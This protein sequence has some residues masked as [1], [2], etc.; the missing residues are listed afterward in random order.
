MKKKSLA[1]IRIEVLDT[2]IKRNQKNEDLI[3]QLRN[4][5]VPDE[6]TI[7][8]TDLLSEYTSNVDLIEPTDLELSQYS[9]WFYLKDKK[10]FGA[11]KK[12]SGFLNPII[13]KGSIDE[14]KNI[15]LEKSMNIDFNNEFIKE[16][17][18]VAKTPKYTAEADSDEDYL[19]QIIDDFEQDK[20]IVKQVNPNEIITIEESLKLYNE[21]ISEDEIKAWVY[22]KRLY[23]NPMRGYEKYYLKTQGD[24]QNVVVS[25]ESFSIKNQQFQ[26]V[27]TIPPN[28][29]LGIKTKFKNE[30]DNET[31]IVVRNEFNE[32]FYVPLSKIEEKN[33]GNKVDETELENLVRKKALCYNDGEYQPIPIF[34][35]GNLYDLRD[36]LIGKFDK[37]LSKYTGG[38]IDKIEDK[39]GKDVAQWHKEVLENCIKEKGELLFNNPDKSRRPFLSRDNELSESFKIKELNEFSGVNFEKIYQEKRD[40]L[41]RN[42]R[43]YKEKYRDYNYNFETEY[44]LFEAFEFWFNSTINDTMLENTTKLN[45]QRL[46]INELNYVKQSGEEDLSTEEINAKKLSAKIEGEKL[47]NEFI[48]TCLIDSD[49][50]LLNTLFNRQFNNVAK[51]DVS[52]IPVAFEANK[53]VFSDPEF[54]LKLVQRNGLAFMSATNGGCY[55]YGVG[56]GK[57][58]CAIHT[59]AS[60]LKEGKVKRPLIV[61]P[62]PVYKNWI[63]E[64]FG[65]YSNGVDTS[66]DDFE[67]AKFISGALTGLNYKFN[68]WTNLTSYDIQNKEVEPYTIT[69]VTYQGA[70]KIGYSPSL[71]EAFA[72]ELADILKGQSVGDTD[73][74]D[75]KTERKKEILNQSIYSKLG[76]AESETKIDIDICGFDYL[77]VDEAHNFKN[78]FGTASLDDDKKDSWKLA[79]KNSTKRAIK[80]FLN[81]LY[82][83]RKYNGNVVLLTATPF[84]N[85]PLE[86]YSMMSLVGYSYLKKYNIQNMQSFLSLFIETISEYTVDHT[87]KIKVGTV[88]KSFQNKNILR[89]VLY[90]HFD[91]QDNPELAGVSRPCKINF[92]N[93]KVNTYLSMSDTQ[94]Q[95]REIIMEEVASYDPRTNRGAMGRALNWSK[96]NSLCPFL[97]PNVPDF[98]SIEEFVNESPKI[99]YTID[100]INSV[101]KYADERG[102]LVS[103]QVIYSNR[104][105]S[106]FPVIKQALNEICDFKKKV[107]FGNEIVDEV[108][109][110][111]S[112]NSLAD[113][114]R[115]EI[116]KD[117]FN[118]GY[119]KVIIGTATIKEGVNLQENGSV[120][121]NLDLDWNPTDFIQ[122]EGRI[123][124]QGNKFKYVRIVV[125]LVQNTLDSFINQKL[126]EKSKRIATIWDKTSITATEN[127][128]EEN[129]MVDPMEIKFA[130]IDDKD[131]LSKMK[132]DEAAKKLSKKLSI[133]E[134]RYKSIFKI[135]QSKNDYLYHKEELKGSF[136][137]TL[138][139][140]QKLDSYLF[141]F[142][143]EK[144]DWTTK[145]Q[146]SIDKAIKNLK[147]LLLLLKEYD[148]SG[149]V[150]S[151]N[152][153]NRQMN[154]RTFEFRYDERRYDY[155]ELSRIY[156]GTSEWGGI[157]KLYSR[158]L[159][160]MIA[161]YGDCK[162][163]ERAVLQSYGMTLADDLSVVKNKFLDELNAVKE[164]IEFMSTEDYKNSVYRE[165]EE[166]LSKRARNRGGIEER[167][168]EFETSNNLLTYPFDKK[169]ANNCEYPINDSPY[170]DFNKVGVSFKLKEFDDT[171]SVIR[172]SKSIKTKKDSEI[173]FLTAD[174]KKFVPDFQ[175]KIIYKNP[176]FEDA[177]VRVNEQVANCPKT[178][179]TE[180]IDT[181]EKIAQLHYFRGES[182]WYII[183][184]DSEDRQL[185][186]FGYVILNGDEQ[187]AEFGYINIEEVKKYAELDL[188]WTPVKM[189]TLLS[190]GDIETKLEDA[191]KETEV[192]SLVVNEAIDLLSNLL[193]V[194]DKKMVKNAKEA[195]EL[196]KNLL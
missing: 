156:G 116:I 128:I 20:S 64:L 168:A 93:S 35:F 32:L 21:S 14:F 114:E 38:Y 104:G 165:I 29:Q 12:G 88:I 133:A 17:I 106:I 147:E 69:L 162:K 188:Y 145:D 192:T 50:F 107:K 15:K 125:P 120:L 138:S 90:R 190:D 112:A 92:P 113:I 68:D 77:V 81:S 24:S 22:Y 61:V 46:Y 96:S 170:S 110:V 26:D 2:L 181:E 134:D 9:N 182:D 18:I 132:I 127:K 71:R 178:Y 103:G 131:E 161:N 115:K 44:T 122:L 121:Y 36:S 79:R 135:E 52:K 153:A 70:E 98:E 159:Q 187:N 95:A 27:K 172:K 87:N 173:T 13:T 11:E 185:Q 55:A 58:L 56:F 94:V 83:Q 97:V 119:V 85:S 194:E 19:E 59:I 72:R 171:D 155:S 80:L 136:E 166:E 60:V 62:K 140:V 25:K 102:Q 183:E 151:L 84:T 100:C 73:D 45:I 86:I 186:A 49:I 10:I 30:Y 167:V 41:G 164:S 66:F 169:D 76:V 40:S 43:E 31:W 99:K 152:E 53:N 108:E 8:Y 118:K 48:S 101:K 117:A 139:R 193:E 65:F 141:R 75:K 123:H 63:K 1:Q 174:A 176:E 47:Y 105:K 3:I 111:T 16:H 129:A 158:D 37:E 5:Y 189:G 180:G 78:V 74:D 89:D 142:K 191:P 163:F 149:D 6:L 33:I 195:I 109:I 7:E 184:K 4:G 177:R 144:N 146:E 91:Y 160:L 124:R 23:G 28:T 175:Y 126:D 196:L 42:S 130:L 154:T 150:K 148:N 67:G 143:N 157:N 82:L 54:K 137:E 179:Q 57:T 34:T 51:L 39:F